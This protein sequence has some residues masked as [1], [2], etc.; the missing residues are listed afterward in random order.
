MS[1]PENGA[2]DMLVQ[3]VQ[4]GHQESLPAVESVLISGN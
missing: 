1:T 4:I 2:S 3:S